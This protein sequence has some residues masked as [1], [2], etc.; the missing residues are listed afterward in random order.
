MPKDP[1]KKP[2]PA[3]VNEEELDATQ[4]SRPIDESEEDEPTKVLDW[5]RAMRKSIDVDPGKP[6]K[7]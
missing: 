6:P 3:P 1:P 4:P 2:A 7:R 5:D